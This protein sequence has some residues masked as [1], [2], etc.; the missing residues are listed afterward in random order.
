M[1]DEI[2][3]ISSDPNYVYIFGMYTNIEFRT[4][5]EL[6]LQ[7]HSNCKQI[8]VFFFSGTH[9]QNINSYILHLA[10]DSRPGLVPII[11]L[12][13]AICRLLKKKI[14][15][16]LQQYYFNKSLESSNYAVS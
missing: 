10:C 13:T 16:Q 12:H 5:M 3:N 15:K 8:F 6:K 1:L 11:F 14:K 9:H 7:I 4:T 2:T